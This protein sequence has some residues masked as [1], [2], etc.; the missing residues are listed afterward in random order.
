MY[1]YT[2]FF[3]PSKYIN[4]RN[5]YMQK[6]PKSR[7][8]RKRLA[9]SSEVIEKHVYQLL[10]KCLMTKLNQNIGGRGVHQPLPPSLAMCV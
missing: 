1:K 10:L 4:I 7:K 8:T 2:S 5:G 6:L 9:L 3:T